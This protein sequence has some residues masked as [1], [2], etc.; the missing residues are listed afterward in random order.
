MN[1][2]NALN[3]SGCWYQIY[4]NKVECRT[5]MTYIDFKIKF[6]DKTLEE[7]KIECDELEETYNGI[8]D[9][10]NA[11]YQGVWNILGYCGIMFLD[12]L[13]ASRQYVTD[14][15]VHDNK[16]VRQIYIT[17]IKMIDNEL[18]SEY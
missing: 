1:Q 2:V 8:M 6:E 18:K 11:N 5:G 7:L 3:G 4:G 9:Q 15:S 16:T 14:D 17:G 13:E 12:W 10:K